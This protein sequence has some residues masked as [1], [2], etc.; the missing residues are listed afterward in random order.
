MKNT[1]NL[2]QEINKM[3]NVNIVKE[4]KFKNITEVELNFLLKLKDDISNIIDILLP[5]KEFA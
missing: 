5:K 4:K 1:E 3:L 2:N